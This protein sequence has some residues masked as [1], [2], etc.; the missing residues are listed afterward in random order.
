VPRP[1][2]AGRS[3]PID[4]GRARDLLGFTA[5]YPYEV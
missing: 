4:L 2:F 5:A 1:H 3:V